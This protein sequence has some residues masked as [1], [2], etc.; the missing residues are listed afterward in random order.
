MQ[1]SAEI[2]PAPVCLPPAG[3]RTGLKIRSL[4][5]AHMKC[6]H[7]GGRAW[8]PSK[9]LPNKLLPFRGHSTSRRKL[10]TSIQEITMF[11]DQ[12][13][14]RWVQLNPVIAQYQQNA[15]YWTLSREMQ[16][17]GHTYNVF[18]YLI[19]LRYDI[20]SN[21]NYRRCGV[22]GCLHNQSK[23]SLLFF[24]SWRTGEINVFADM[25]IQ[26]TF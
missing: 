4:L 11:Q 1:L 6:D 22:A 24:L 19:L 18:E 20:M 15:R 17:R 13:V 16:S 7:V 12:K 21:D 5:N 25:K 9:M 2:A 14:H 8:V 26:L 10:W 3:D 23:R